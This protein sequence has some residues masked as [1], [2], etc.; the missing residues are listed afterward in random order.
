LAR[1]IALREGIGDVLA[2]GTYRAALKLGKMKKLDLLGYVVHSK[3]I[4]IGA[5]GTRSGKDYPEIISYACGVQGGDHTSTTGLPLEGNS[6]LME[7]FNDSGVFCNF[8]TFSGPRN[9]RFDMYEAVTGLKLTRREWCRSRGMK[10]LQLQRAML[11][12]GGPDAWW[13]P[14]VDDDN[15]PR[16]YEPL[17]SGPM[18]GKTTDRKAVEKYKQRYYRAVGW[19]KYGFPTSEALVKLGLKDVDVALEKVRNR[20]SS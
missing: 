14:R 9:V 13:D 1:K 17:P 3:G 5:H 19:D 15:P 11:L 12:L 4:S 20:I 6:E 10:T 8:N 16:F 18:K 2:E 7:I